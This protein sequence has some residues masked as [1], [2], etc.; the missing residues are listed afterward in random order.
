M[1][2]FLIL[3]NQLQNSIEA[4]IRASKAGFNFLQSVYWPAKRVLQLALLFW[5]SMIWSDSITLQ[6]DSNMRLSA[7]VQ[8]A[9]GKVL[10]E[11]V[12]NAGDSSSWS[13]DYEYFGYDAE[14]TNPPTPYT[15]NWYCMSGDLF[16]T[17]TDVG[18]ES[19]VTAL[20]CG[21]AQQCGEN[22]EDE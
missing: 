12:I 10:E 3:L 14:Q 9:T 13:L 15:V 19:T 5:Q 1:R 16:G 7:V 17:C 2:F 22:S 21:G 8:D 18:S 20:S 4:Q 11:V 6:N